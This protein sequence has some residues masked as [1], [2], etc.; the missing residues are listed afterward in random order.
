MGGIFGGGGGGGGG[1]AAAPSSQSVS[2]T[3]I[4]DYA[5]P[6]VETLLGQTQA[7]TDINQNPFQTYG[8]QRIAGFTPMQTQAFQNIAGQT[9]AP[10]LGEASNMAS[11]AGRGSMTAFGQG[12]QLGQAG[13]GYGGMGAGYGAQAA[14]MAGMGF[15]A[16]QQYAQ[17]ATSPGA[18]AAYMSPYMQNAVDWQKQQ[19]VRDYGV[20]QQGRKAQAVGQGAYGGSRQAVAEG[21]ANR[22]LMNQLGGIQAQGTQKA[23]EQAQQA[24]QFGANLGLQGLQAGYQGLGMGIQGAQT[25]LQGVGAATQAG[26]YGLQGL[27]QGLQAASTLGQLGQT[28]FGQQQAINQALQQAGAQQQAMQQ[29][30][31]DTQ[32]QDFLKQRNYPYQQLAFMSDML[33]GLPLSQASQ[34]V[35]TAPPSALSQ[36]GGLGMTGLGIYGM[37]GGFKGAT[38]GLPKDFKSYKKGGIASYSI[39]GDISMMS[40]KQLQELL[41]NPNLTPREMDMVEEQLMIRRR[42]ESNPESQKIMASAEQRSGIGAIAT[43][44]MVP[45]EMAGGGIVAF[46]T[47]DLATLQNPK[48]SQDVKDQR[49]EERARQSA[50]FKRLFEEQDPFAESKAQEADIKAQLA[51]SRKSS[52]WEALTMAGLGTLAGTS[53]YGLSNLGQ[54]AMAGMKNYAQSKSEQDQLQKLLLQQGVEREKSKFSRDVALHNALTNAI[55]QKDTKEIALMNAKTTA[56][57]SAANVDYQNFLKASTIYS[58]ALAKEK[59][60]LYRANKDRFN[61]DVDNAELDMEAR[62]NVAKTMPKIAEVVGAGAPVSPID[63]PKPEANPGAANKPA[64]DTKSLLPMPTRKED[65]VKGKSYNTYKGPGKWDGTQFIPIQVRYMAKGFSFEEAL[66]PTVKGFSFEEALP[67]E[68]T[69]SPEEQVTSQVGQTSGSTAADLAKL[70]AAGAVKGTLGAPEAVQ[71]GV[72]ATARETAFAPTDILNLIADPRALTNKLVG[73]VGIPPVFEEKKFVPE[74]VTEKQKAAVD[75]VLTKGKIPQLRTLTEFGNRISADLENTISPEM[76]QALAESQP[77]GNILKALETGDFSEVSFGSKPTVLGLSGQ[78]AKVFGSAFPAFLTAA[79]TKKAGPAAAV[80]F[81]QAGAEGVDEARSYIDKMTDDELT[82]KSEYFRNLVALGYKPREAR[83]MTVNK[84]GDTAALYQGTVG[85]LGG[86]F[87]NKL[88]HGA[89]DKTLLSSAKSRLAKIVQG[90]ALGAGEGGLSEMAEGVATDLGIDKAVVR[91][92]GVDSFANLVLGAL[93]EGAP[94]TVRGAIAP[95]ETPSKAGFSF[96]QA[97]APEP[98][99]PIAPAPVAAAP[100]VPPAAPSTAAPVTPIGAGEFEETP[101]VVTPEAPVTPAPEAAPVTA[102]TPSEKPTFDQWRTEQGLTFRSKED[103]EAALPKLKAQYEAEISGVPA[104]KEQPKVKFA[105]DETGE[106]LTYPMF[107]DMAE[108]GYQLHSFEHPRT[109]ENKGGR[110]YRTLEKD[111]VRI[112]LEPQQVLFTDPKKPNQQPQLGMGNENDVAFHFIGVDPE[113]RKQ[114]KARKALQDLIDVADKN[115]YTLYGEPAQLEKEGMTKEQLTA[116]YADYGFK[117]KDETGKVIVREP[118]A[119][120]VQEPVQ[121]PKISER[122]KNWL[123]GKDEYIKSLVDE[124]ISEAYAKKVY[125]GQIKYIKDFDKAVATEDPDLLV[126]AQKEKDILE[127]KLKGVIERVKG[128]SKEK[129]VS[130]NKARQ[131]EKK[132]AAEAKKA[133]PVKAAKPAEKIVGKELI[134]SESKPIS[135]SEMAKVG[136]RIGN[137]RYAQDDKIA[138][139]FNGQDFLIKE[140]RDVILVGADKDIARKWIAKRYGYLLE[141]FSGEKKPEVKE[142]HVEGKTQEPI[143]S[144]TIEEAI[145]KAESNVDYNKIKTAVKN[146]FDQAIKRAKIQTEKEWAA[147][148]IDKNS[149]VTIDIPGDGKFK[150]KN[151]VERL[152]ELQTKI[153]NAVTPKAPKLPTGPSSGSLEAFKSMVDEK[154]MENAIEYAK[155][156]GLDPKTV[157]LNPAQRTTVDKY[158]KNPAEFERQKE[159]SEQMAEARAT[160]LRRDQEKRVAERLEADEKREEEA[161][162]KAV[163][164]TTIRSTEAQLKSDIKTRKISSKDAERM[165]GVFPNMPEGTVKPYT[166]KVLRNFVTPKTQPNIELEKKKTIKER[167]QEI[168]DEKINEYSRLRQRVAHLTRK[169]AEGKVSLGLQRELNDLLE[170]TKELKQDVK[171]TT[172]KNNTPEHFYKKALEEYTKKNIDKDVLDV[173]K[174]FYD[175]SPDILNGIK[176]SVRQADEDGVMGNFAPMQRIVTLYKGKGAESPGT[177]RHEIM[178]SLEQM[179]NSETRQAVIDSWS[180]AL[181]NAITQYGDD[182]RSAKY[183]N[184]VLD[185]IN[186]PNET[187]FKRAVSIMPSKDFYQYINPSEY[188]AVNAEKLMAAKMGTPWAKFVR[189]V[190]GLAERLKA[191]FGLE[192]DHAIHKAFNN[193]IKGETKRMDKESLTSYLNAAA[194]NF[195]FL[196]DIKDVDALLEKHNRP[197][198]PLHPSGEVKDTILGSYQKS[199]KIATKMAENPLMTAVNMVGKAD[200]AITYARNKNVWYGSGL[201][202]ADFAKYNG[203]LRNSQ[204][205]AA[206]SVAVTNTIH[207]GHVGTQVMVQGKLMFD[208]KT[209]MF[210][211]EK[212]KNSLANVV[213]LKHD[214]EE[215]LG[216]Q[217]AANVVNAYFEAKRSRSIVNEYLNRTANYEAA[218]ESG[219]DLE[220]ASKHLKSIEIAIQKVN[221]DDE[222]IDDFIALEK[223]YPELRQMMDNWTAVNHNLIDVNVFAGVYSKIRGKQLKAIKDYV[224]WYR[225]MDDMTDIHMPAGVRGM[226]NVGQEKKFKAGEVDR[227]IDDIVDNMI[228]NVMMMTRNSMRN[229]ANNRIAMEYATRNEKGKIKLYPTEG[230]DENGVRVNMIANGR[231]VVVNIPDPLIAEASL[232]MENI[233]IPMIDILSFF[234]QG[235]R[236]GITT[237][238]AFQVAQLFMDAPTAAWVS[239]VKNPAAVWAGTFGS[240]IRALKPHDPIVD[241]L[242][243]YGIGGYQ[244]SARTPEK[245]MKLEIGL[246]DKSVWART[247][248][249]LDHIGDASDYSQRRAVYKQVLKET[250]DEMQALIQANNVID[251]LKRGSGKGAQFVTRTVSFMNAYAQSIDVLAQAL[252]GGGLKGKTRNQARAQMLKTGLLLAGTTLLYCMA[253]GA[254]DEYNK[255]DD[256]T[257]IRNIIIPGTKIRL[258]MHTSASFFFKSIPE[259]IYNKVMKEGTKNQ[260]DWTRLKTAL[261]KAAADS[262]LGPNMIP[263][264]VKP[265]AEIALNHNFFTGG[266]VTPRG[267]EKLESFRQYNNSTSELGKVLSALT[268]GVLNPIEMDHLVR[269]LFGTAGAAVMYGSNLFSGDRVSP[270]AKDNPLYGSFVLPEVPRGREDL[271]YDLKERSDKKYETFLDMMKKQ[272]PKEAQEYRAENKGLI[273]A[274]GFVTGADADLKRINAEIRRLSDLPAEKMSSEEK[275]A[276]ITKFQEQKNRIL[277]KTIEFRLRAEL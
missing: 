43:G 167:T 56:S 130:E 150:V 46:A 129:K 18:M 6:Y 69:L 104:P 77:T 85:A 133:K 110:R 262:L 1:Q 61:F 221:M 161:R 218:I 249:T 273:A 123:A 90:T 260:V 70:T 27:G 20:A 227:D 68:P 193:L 236:R 88:L 140:P 188:W 117:P 136:P 190:K 17:Q 24:Q 121:E 245:E 196:N 128:K 74:K 203:Q 246:I 253:V 72:S 212:D 92:I 270:Q 195:D 84:A 183:F 156:K 119:E 171:L 204:G 244:S 187:N 252:A 97:V 267:M 16:G 66:Q 44:D 75:E 62:N 200:R 210:R 124:G 109:Y 113:L 237:N 47:G 28:Q 106:R 12:Q 78:A 268:G 145:D 49:D 71:A 269:G 173:V 50:L 36:I 162:F 198:T 174:Y 163:L 240:F 41:N 242:K 94:G 107:A 31:L 235:L 230:K 39:G 115:D 176:L 14:G 258:P 194:A 256:Q 168:H 80:G 82:K 33:R 91:E 271:F 22:A 220:E 214:L 63:A 274:H 89:F 199:K 11:Q 112:A 155:L 148:T 21:E 217:R 4:P 105:E 114:G 131:A 15:G 180:G 146:Q 152:K 202:Q 159:E 248:K 231:R 118:G 101:A 93:G 120:V 55:S 144:K 250:G 154:D 272:H 228:H 3:T 239:G 225:I 206:A 37:S 125:D 153:A 184:A 254:D 141:P 138:F 263:T 81:G 116:L 8:G 5:R 29:Q 172:P 192:N 87:T 229:Y 197:D 100:V 67:P 247:M 142:A 215:K 157:K 191:M 86:V 58:N 13:L 53:Q 201:E 181:K 35:Y 259:L 224:P 45:E 139:T 241:M 9:V 160:A 57:A 102:V 208:P 219:E 38:G 98:T 275:R 265:I 111:G 166:I 223:E 60:A 42:M 213:R 23:Y 65:L 233:E 158:L 134:E 99:A 30:G 257:K 264:G 59:A 182:Q 266:T 137:I 149:Y 164:D 178:H 10:Q 127:S 143:T 277:E 19:A 26:Q 189:F 48:V 7:L 147:A 52:P 185:F 79:V 103:Y 132:A 135:F 165:L 226:T 255:L 169:V 40:T 238:P 261:G 232:G 54:G 76:K 186:V 108:K 209:Q 32:Y 211:A 234:A 2:Q 96:E 207:A 51:A 122:L 25:G 64:V 73:A 175:N 95:T 251:F 205:L 151:N 243:S 34:Q 222:A 83:E 216:A 177:A 170:L 179:M 276:R 126:K